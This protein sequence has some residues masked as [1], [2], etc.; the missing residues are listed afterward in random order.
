MQSKFMD[1]GRMNTQELEKSKSG[2]V[3][4]TA[5]RR[6]SV[7]SNPLGFSSGRPKRQGLG[8]SN[9]VQEILGAADINDPSI[10]QELEEDSK[11]DYTA[12]AIDDLDQLY[13]DLE[14]SGSSS[15][16]SGGDEKDD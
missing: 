15:D 2:L 12:E 9:N 3:Q 5:T 14:N 10:I 13:Q 6:Q 8:L 4:N 1:M 7:L 16:N 11:P